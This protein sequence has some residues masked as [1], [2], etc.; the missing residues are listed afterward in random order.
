VIEHRFVAGATKLLVP[1]DALKSDGEFAAQAMTYNVVDTYNTTFSQGAFSDYLSSNP[2]PPILWGHQGSQSPTNVLG[3]V[4]DWQDQPGG[5]LVIGQ[6]DPNNPHFD[7]VRGQLQSRSIIGVS[8]GFVRKQD[9]PSL[10]FDGVTAIT[11]ADLPEISLVVEPSVPGAQV[12]AIRNR[13]GR[14]QRGFDV[15]RE[16]ERIM[17]DRRL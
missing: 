6:L 14:R 17:A 16:A 10:L 3:Q 8:V 1:A 7:L 4:V 15:V 12:L 5:L 11:Q 13:S 9:E 2:L